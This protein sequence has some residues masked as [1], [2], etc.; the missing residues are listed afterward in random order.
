MPAAKRHTR[1]SLRRPDFPEGTCL[2]R[3]VAPTGPLPGL[4]CFLPFHDSQRRGNHGDKTPRRLMHAKFVA[5]DSRAT[6]TSAI[7]KDANVTYR[8]T[9]ALLWIGFSRSGSYDQGA[10]KFDKANRLRKLPGL[11]A[12]ANNINR[13][14]SRT[15]RHDERVHLT[16]HMPF[17][18]PFIR[19]V[20]PVIGFGRIPRP[21]GHVGHG[22]PNAR[23][24]L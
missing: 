8:T 1:P 9:S 23:R 6:I 16:P 17:V 19:H 12:K 3:D 5:N 14:L 24:P 7:R 13:S 20:A 11:W 18:T 2:P 22:H 21:A 10:T 15:L 4:P